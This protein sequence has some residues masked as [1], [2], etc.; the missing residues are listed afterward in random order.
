MAAGLFGQLN[1][2]AP[3]DVPALRYSDIDVD[4]SLNSGV[5]IARASDTKAGG[6]PVARASY[7]Q[8][9]DVIA[10]VVMTNAHGVPVQ[11][12]RQVT[13]LQAQLLG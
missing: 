5:L 12:Y 10:S 9:G 6:E 2:S 8:Y 1:F 13:L 7:L 3:K 4:A 11:A